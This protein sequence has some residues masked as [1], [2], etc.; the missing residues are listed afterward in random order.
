[1][2]GKLQNIT[3]ITLDTRSTHRCTNLMQELTVVVVIVEQA[4]TVALER[5]VVLLYETERHT[6]RKSGVGNR[7]ESRK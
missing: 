7:Q 6:R 4:A 3:I 2:K 1:M 5:F